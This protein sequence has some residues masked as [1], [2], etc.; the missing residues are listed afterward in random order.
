M[1]T[2]EREMETMGHYPPPNPRSFRRPYHQNSHHRNRRRETGLHDTV[3]KLAVESL[4]PRME[5][6]E[7]Y[8]LSKDKG[9]TDEQ[10]RY[11]RHRRELKRNRRW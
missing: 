7:K 1:K 2:T 3:Q 6:P 11:D 8:T 5:D 9:K 4:A 10:V